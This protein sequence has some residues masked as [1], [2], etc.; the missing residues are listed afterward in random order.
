MKEKKT[1]KDFG[2]A[3]EELR[4]KV[5]DPYRDKP[6]SYDNLAL[7]M[8][9][10]PKYGNKYHGQSWVTNYCR[11]KPG[12]IPKEKIIEEFADYFNLSPYYFFEYRLIRLLKLLNRDRRFLDV[13]EKSMI[14]YKS[15]KRGDDKRI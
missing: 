9:Y 12:K 4:V 6:L 10:N 2:L 11:Y 1:Y 5:R 3:L 8:S 14:K 7:G 15:L 13:L